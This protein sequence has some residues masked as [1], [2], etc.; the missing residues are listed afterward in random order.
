MWDSGVCVSLSLSD[1]TSSRKSR[2]KHPLWSSH[3][4]PQEDSQTEWQD[5]ISLQQG[6]LEGRRHIYH[7]QHS[8][9]ICS[10]E[11]VHIIRV[12]EKTKIKCFLSSLCMSVLTNISANFLDNSVAQNLM[13]YAEYTHTHT[14]TLAQTFLI[15]YCCEKK[16]QKKT[17]TTKQKTLS[18]A[19]VFNRDTCMCWSGSVWHI[20]KEFFRKHELK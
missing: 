9:H 20:C 18:H 10:E 6:G 2:P 11:R 5:L 12:K 14:H 19:H 3:C 13:P 4:V 17:T 1:P 16:Q 15:P 7:G 8:E